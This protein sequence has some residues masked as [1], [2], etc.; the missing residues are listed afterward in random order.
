MG[1]SVLIVPFF[2]G[3]FDIIPDHIE[4]TIEK[5]FWSAMVLLL[6]S[7]MLFGLFFGVTSD[8]QQQKK[9]KKKILLAI[10]IICI[11]FWIIGFFS[12]LL[13]SLGVLKWMPEN[14][15][16]PLAHIGDIDVNEDGKL[17]VL[18]RFYGRIQMYDQKGNFIRGWFYYA[19]S[20]KV[21][22]KI[23]DSNEVEVAAFS[24]GKIYSFNEYGRLLE[25]KT[26][27]DM[28]NRYPSEDDIKHL[29]VKSTGIKYDAKGLI[30]PRIIQTGPEGK[31]KI[32][33]NAFYLFTFQGPVQ[34]FVM[35]FI[36]MIILTKIKKKKSK[37]RKSKV[38]SK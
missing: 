15:E 9:W 6:F 7:G 4:P 19:P 12:G 26:F 27:E 29:F 8:I 36:G 2:L 33:N 32:G 28:Y 38:S 25:T 34:A 18:S 14:I 31:K 16:F 37:K 30:F 5:I 35:G 11:L 17:L 21:S 3:Y 22:M 23:T 10:G 24:S 20:G 13:S 1:K